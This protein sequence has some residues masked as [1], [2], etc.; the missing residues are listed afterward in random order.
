MDARL[1]H[2]DFTHVFYDPSDLLSL[3]LAISSLI[4]QLILVVYTTQFFCR[5]E[6]ET[7]LMV[8]GQVLSELL[9]ELLKSVIRQPRPH[10]ELGSGYGMP[11]AH[12][13]FMAFYAAYLTAWTLAH[14]HFSPLKKALRITWV[15]GLCALVSYSRVYLNY[16]TP[17]QVAVGIAVGVLFGLGWHR[18][19][20][21]MRWIGLVDW[22]LDHVFLADWFY[23][24]DSAATSGS[25][26]EDE[27]AQWKKQRAAT[28]SK[29]A[30]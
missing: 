7:C 26:V 22:V 2:L 19:V 4:P 25:F 21:F 1:T 12:A 27:Y 14:A 3:P 11:S 17:A 24:K 13:Q 15:V 10:L 18:A 5:R 20:L 8:A 23:V 29:K 16:H 28:R 9:N 6:I 30:Q